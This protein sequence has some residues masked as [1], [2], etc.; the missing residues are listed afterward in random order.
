MKKYV[1][2]SIKR[3]LEDLSARKVAPGGGSAAALAASLGA[4]LNLMVINYTIFKNSSMARKL[5]VGQKNSLKKLTRFVDEDCEVFK[6]LMKALS[7]GKAAD[8]DFISAASVPLKIC[9][10]CLKSLRITYTATPLLNKN[11][12]TDVECAALVLFAAFYAAKLNV[13]INLKFIK[14][15]AVRRKINVELEKMDKEIITRNEKI[16]RTV[17]L[18]MRGKK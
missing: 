16:S 18:V 4:G 8:D 9:H 7:R 11:L 12:I 1:N 6:R 17:E 2:G 15:R 13:T 3:Y 5:K 10:E 14:D